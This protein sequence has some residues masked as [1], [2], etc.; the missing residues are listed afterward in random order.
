MET[1][2][3]ECPAESADLE[4]LTRDEMRLV[5]RKIELSLKSDVAL[6]NQMGTYIVQAGGKRM[7][8][9]LVLISALAHGYQ[10]SQHI[11]LAAIIEFIHTATLLHDDVVDS[12]GMRRGRETANAVW[13]NEAAVLVGDF[14]YSRSFEMMVDVGEMRVMEILSAATNTI[15]AGEVMQ[16]LNIGEPDISEQVYMEV[17]N[18]KTAKLFEAAA[19]LGAVIAQ[20]GSTAELAMARYGAHLGTAFQLVDDLLDYTAN[21]DELG[22]NVG[23]DLAEGKPTL[24]LIYAMR[25]GSDEAR[26]CIR[27]ALVCDGVPQSLETIV[28]A[29]VDSG[30]IEKT[31]Q[32]AAEQ[33][34]LAIRNLDD[35]ED[36]DFKA[37][38]LSIA[39]SS[40]ERRW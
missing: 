39:L 6:I 37:A 23:D 4:L 32:K 27:E 19:R 13:G 21:A 40:V 18:A 8:P 16:L 2:A 28:A 30:A 29:V 24:P 5:N 15:A 1:S 31:R 17:I 36:S 34:E 35:L 3:H 33:V 11:D 10:G 9:R 7:R 25:D 12:S 20:A 38:L 14:L 26:N 22:K